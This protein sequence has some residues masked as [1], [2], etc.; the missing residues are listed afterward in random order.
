MRVPLLDGPGL[1][2]GR[3]CCRR[4]P[5]PRTQA[6]EPG[7][8]VVG[9]THGPKF[10]FWLPGPLTAVPWKPA[11]RNCF[12]GTKIRNIHPMA[13]V[14]AVFLSLSI[15]RELWRPRKRPALPLPGTERLEVP[16]SKRFLIYLSSPFVLS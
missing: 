6:Q 12:V 9:Q 10:P 2:V 1:P 8:I 13:F 14:G 11:S 3:S 16:H 4:R 15:P 5:S 7:G